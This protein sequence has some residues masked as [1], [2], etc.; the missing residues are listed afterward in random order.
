MTR[1]QRVGPVTMM[2]NANSLAVVIGV[3]LSVLSVREW[4]DGSGAMLPAL[5]ALAFTA[6][7][8]R[9]RLR[10]LFIGER[11]VRSRSHVVSRTVRWAD[12]ETFEAQPVSRRTAAFLPARAKKMD[13]QAICVVTKDGRT[14]A[15]PLWFQP[16][17][18]REP[19]TGDS[20]ANVLSLQDGQQ[21][22]DQ[23]RDRLATSRQAT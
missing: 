18:G 9:L 8:I 21:A 22:L 10:G 5:F 1:W 12:V 16:K 15:T 13:V 14:V 20:L 2:I 7:A 23:L 3:V 4:L 17:R 19:A 11:G 6:I